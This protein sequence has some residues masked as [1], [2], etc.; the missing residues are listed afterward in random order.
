VDDGKNSAIERLPREN[1]SQRQRLTAMA[2]G[3]NALI[4]YPNTDAGET[5]SLQALFFDN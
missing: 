4:I 5:A 1:R 3:A 2:L